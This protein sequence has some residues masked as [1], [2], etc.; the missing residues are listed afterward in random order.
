[1]RRFTEIRVIGF[2]SIEDQSFDF[3]L[4]GLNIFKGP[5]GA[6][7]TTML[8]ALSWA[9][10]KQPLKEVTNIPTW[11]HLRNEG[12]I[13]TMVESICM[14]DEEEHKIIRC[15]KYKGEVAG[16]KG[17]DG[18]FYFI[19]GNQF[20]SYKN[21][22]DLNKIIIENLGFSF[23]LF[24]NTIVFGQKMK[25][26]IEE[27]GAKQKSVFDEIFE[28]NY[29]N[30]AREGCRDELD[31]TTKEIIELNGNIGNLDMYIIDK[32]EIIKIL[33]DKK[34]K[35][36][37]VI[38]DKKL[39]I[40]EKISQNENLRD[41]HLNSSKLLNTILLSPTN[42][43]LKPISSTPINMSE[44]QGDLYGLS[45]KLINYRK[46]IE[47]LS[48][49]LSENLQICNTCNQSIGEEIHN[50]QMKEVGESKTK[51]LKASANVELLKKKLEKKL[52]KI[53]LKTKTFKKKQEVYEKLQEQYNTE[54]LEIEK[55]LNQKEKGDIYIDI[56]N[57]LKTELVQVK[58]DFDGELLKKH[59][60]S[61]EKS[62]VKLKEYQEILGI[63]QSK[64]ENLR[65]LVN[66]SLSNKGIKAYLFQHLI[67]QL[68]EE[69]LKYETIAEGI[70]EFKINKSSAAQNFTITFTKNGHTVPFNDLSGGQAQLV[71]VVI[72]FG[73]HELTMSNKPVNILL[74]DEAFESLSEDNIEKVTTL[75]ESKA[76]NS[77]VFLVTH[78]KSFI[79][80]NSKVF[81]FSLDQ[82]Y[83]SIV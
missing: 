20:L 1:M 22:I 67:I 81:N 69:L 77:T 60:R 35:E 46:D 28:S 6:G 40:K 80:T 56:I 25:R 29:I 27:T 72:A 17:G 83:T 70:I 13:G 41:Q 73:M 65:W 51:K 14:I 59:K 66:D 21:K 7:K 3:D 8:S 75:I 38:K 30:K 78:L 43:P 68:N 39:K 64:C 61:V 42:K 11:P 74:M 54:Q 37:Q 19:N 49:R 12:W 52:E 57:N 71:N 4:G 50:Q 24:K 15:I 63:A 47:E 10:Y 44:L 58:G 32:A 23:E 34:L 33:L 45:N 5:N 62:K 48:N 36:K 31:I 9:W 26:L 16:V 18:L 55:L 79:S 53:S 76:V 82:D 2:G